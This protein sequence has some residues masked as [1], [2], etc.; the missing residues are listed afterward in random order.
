MVSVSGVGGSRPVG[1]QNT[2]GAVVLGRG[3]TWLLVTL[4]AAV[5]IA[6]A[7]WGHLYNETDGQYG[8]AAKT[9]AAGGDWLVPENN[10]IPRLV[11]PPLLYWLMAGGMKVL[12]TNEFAARL[13]GALS[14]VIWLFATAGIA[15]EWGGWHRAALAVSILG[16]LMG[17]FTLARIVM[18]EPLFSAGIALALYCLIRASRAT[19][20]SG[21]VLSFWAAGAIAAFSKGPHGL[22]Y[23][24]VI[25]LVALLSNRFLHGKPDRLMSRFVSLPAVILAA[26][27]LI[28]WH[29]LMEWRFPG[30]LSDLIFT[31]H[32]GHLAG[33]AKPATGYTNVPRWQFLL[34]HLA[35]F[36]PWSA[37]VLFSLPK[38]WRRRCE[39]QWDFPAILIL[40]WGAVILLTVLLA[41]Q[42]QDYYAMSG[43]A[44]FAL[45][46]ASLLERGIPRAASLALAAVLMLALIAC[47]AAPQLASGSATLAVEER[48]TAILTLGGFGP[49]VWHSLALIAGWS[50]GLSVLSLLAAS[51]LRRWALLFWLVCGLA[52]GGGAVAGMSCVAPYFSLGS[53]RP[54]LAEY[55]DALLV[56]DGE[57]DTGSSLLFY[58]DQPVYLLRGEPN[59]VTRRF[60]LGADRYLSVN[61]LRA[62]WISGRQVLLV[63][64]SGRIPG[65]EKSLPSPPTVIGGSG[66]L[67]ILCN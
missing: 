50:L 37:A 15:R 17:S 26:L 42:R 44:V 59:F 40:T 1:R 12:G 66:T 14:V 41:G 10:G 27:I 32:V 5:H 48:S 61:D 47:L 49:E 18:P 13:P 28:P 6:F 64:E 38:W 34:L 39:I 53:A 60:G 23:P 52:L 30:F 3:A 46:G 9:M 8:G 51:F 36:L 67:S 56:F 4:L 16:T 33:Q 20:P 11:K 24:L 65:W 31:E 25:G 54:L 63:T 21:W 29:I 62:M 19:N 35:W 43:W 55:P 22:L 45:V 2:D 58:A 57:I 7:G